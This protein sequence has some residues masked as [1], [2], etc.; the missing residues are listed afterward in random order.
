M[1]ATF[2]RIVTGLVFFCLL[3]FPGICLTAP[4]PVS[5]VD[6]EVLV[7]F[8]KNTDPQRTA[9]IS[10]ELDVVI[11]H[12]YHG[13][14]KRT[15]RRY[16]LLRAKRASSGSRAGRPERSTWEMVR[17]LMKDPSV[18]AVSP[19]YYRTWSVLP[20]DTYFERQWG[21]H[22]TGQSDGLVDADIDAPEAWD[23]QTDC[24]SVILASLD[25]GVDYSHLDLLENMWVNPGEIA[26][27]GVDD[28][29]NGFIDDVHGIDTGEEDS[30]PM[31]KNGHGTHTAGTMAAVGNNGIG[32]AGVCW[33]ARIMAVKA[34]DGEGNIK[35]S[36][37][38]QGIDYVTMMKVDQGHN[39]VAIN[40]SWGSFAYDPILSDAIAAAGDTGI[41]FVAAAGN[42]G[43]DT[44]DYPHYPSSF[45][46]WN[47]LSVAS[48]DARDSLSDFSNHG[49]FSVDLAAP[50]ET[51]WSTLPGYHYDPAPG[52]IFFDDMESGSTHWTTSGTENTWAIS[53]EKAYS[54]S[55]AWNDSPWAD[56]QDVYT[57]LTLNHDI[58]LTAYQ[59]TTVHL[60][61]WAAYHFHYIYDR[62]RVQISADGGSTWTETLVQFED[63]HPEWKLY[64]Y[65]IPENFK[66]ASFRM[67]FMM[68]TN[69]S[70]PADGI[71]ID[72]IGI[73]DVGTGPSDRYDAKD[74]TSM[75]APHVT[76]AAGLLASDPGIASLPAEPAAQQIVARLLKGVDQT[77]GL[78]IEVVTGGRLNVDNAL[79]LGDLPFIKSVDPA[80]GIAEGVPISIEG[81][82][83]GVTGGEL[84]CKVGLGEVALTVSSWS[85]ETI[86][87]DM[88]SRDAVFIDLLRLFVR[89]SGGM[90]SNLV[91]ADRN[92]RWTNTDALPFVSRFGG[93]TSHNGLVY[94]VQGGFGD[95]ETS[96]EMAVY[97]PSTGLWRSTAAMPAPVIERP[98]DVAL[99]MN[100]DGAPMIV[101][102][103]NSF[104]D[105]A[106][107]YRF[108][109]ATETWDA[110]PFPEGFPS[111]GLY[112][113]DIVSML[114]NTGENRC[115]LSGGTDSAA[116]WAYSPA[117]NTVEALGSFSVT[118][119]LVQHSSFYVDW[120]GESGAICVVGGSAGEDTQCFDIAT[121]TFNAPN[122]DL[123]PL[124]GTL[125]EAA[126]GQDGTDL[127]LA[128]GAYNGDLTTRTFFL[129]PSAA[130][131][132]E[133]AR[134]IFPLKRLEGTSVDGILYVAG[135]DYYGDPMW[136]TQTL[137]PVIE[138]LPFQPDIDRDGDVDGVDL[139]AY[140]AGGVFDDIDGFA[141]EFGKVF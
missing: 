53:D 120:L 8:K 17:I 112:D 132:T 123:P 32:V 41:V 69:S 78:N 115:Y 14:S 108:N 119:S 83:F 131:W 114:E 109:L 47:I 103:S 31:D 13:L 60:G 80:Y 92:S 138:P 104:D 27:N 81:M 98:G 72:N 56:Y 44:D 129:D 40:A 95:S 77:V 76:G 140:A 137:R 105:A 19:N 71:C 28:D 26:D 11:A 127:W 35:D 4:P 85:D 29:N 87:F 136:F 128:G 100:G 16:A 82:G 63:Q 70:G 141:G 110:V 74:G 130:E 86:V 6:G 124:P 55:Y 93:L 117:A 50:G 20:D 51:I 101:L 54:G 12:E 94:A 84:V 133:G 68:D 1:T 89:T 62:C 2:H 67:R 102:F 134:L 139:Q 30:D 24:S 65:P 107:I 90:E 118:S 7:K 39:I 3:F 52:D 91:P 113:M 122:T 45:D 22:N 58:D 33:D 59:D 42:N 15:Q 88:P 34:E 66:T 43:I 48:S 9:R 75:A 121:G 49:W 96:G 10:Q 125:T 99:G 116:L 5:Y 111:E 38:I 18:E 21:L 73:G 135:G 79:Q 46:L 23:R 97:D 57:V 25:S 106:G 36:D 61:F 37:L 64:S 126:D